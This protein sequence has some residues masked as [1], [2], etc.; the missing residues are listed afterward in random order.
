MTS[1]VAGREDQ[2]VLIIGRPSGI[3]GAIV[4]A[5]RDA[6]ARVVIAGRDRAPLDTAYANDPDIATDVVDLTDEASIAALAERR[7]TVDHIVSTPSA[8]ARA[9][10]SQRHL[11]RRD[12]HRSLGRLWR[13]A[14]GGL[15][16]AHRFQQPG[17]ADRDGRRRRQRR[18]FRADEHIP[19]WH[20]TAH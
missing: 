4:T 10:S 2:R 20:D 11:A 8:R 6:G 14:Q 7:G 5:A 18:H 16:R 12:R 19:Y 13:A 17:R 3:A 9:D 15:F 1:K